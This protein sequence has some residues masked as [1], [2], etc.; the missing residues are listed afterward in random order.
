MIRRHDAR[1]HV[2][3][4]W[5]SAVGQIGVFISYNHQDK[6]IADAIVEALTSI[7]S[8]LSVFIDHS[9]LEGGDDYDSKLSKS[10]QN[11]HWFIMICSGHS[12]P[13]KDMGWCLYEAGQFRA[14]LELELESQ[15][16]SSRSRMCYLYDSEKPSK[17]TRYQ[18]TCVTQLNRAGSKLNVDLET[19]DSL[20]Y[21]DTELFSLLGLIL[22]RSA[23]QPLR[24][25]TDQNVRK[26][27]RVGVRRVTRAFLT[28]QIDEQVDEI[29][30]QPR[31][32]FRLPLPNGNDPTGLTS[33]TVVLGEDNTFAILFGIA[34]SSTTWGAIKNSNLADYGTEPLWF[35]DLEAAALEMAKG[36]IPA[37]TDS[38]CIAG[39]NSFFRPL[40]ARYEKYQ[41]NAKKCYVV[42]IPAPNRQFAVSLRTSLLL[43]G[44]IL[45]VR[46]R[47][48]VLPIVTDLKA[49]QASSNSLSRKLELL[50]K[51]QKEIIANENESVEF[52]MSM[53]KDEH[54][55]HPVL[56]SF[57]DGP[58]KDKLRDEISW[59]VMARNLI[60]EKI[61]AAKSQSK[62]TSPSDATSFVVEKLEKLSE[63]NSRFITA[64]CEELLYAEK[65]ERPKT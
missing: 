4:S 6:I 65:I 63:I 17:L 1:G 11:S 60:F 9:G 45:S 59:W 56:N 38:I 34:G 21:E 46:F 39:D 15:A 53:P 44:L 18:G 29:V 37:Q 14:K 47:Q 12:R 35:A 25:L 19:D 55:D 41:S 61:S 32:S 33:D 5:G 30:F 43:C 51:L 22:E 20:N 58:Q 24:D 57:R 48:R 42:F 49:L 3:R 64:L 54:D 27:M 31:L 8:D 16:N 13:T 7:S 10:I 28:N 2:N 26:L 36:R 52:G 23:A 40:V 50:T 62:E